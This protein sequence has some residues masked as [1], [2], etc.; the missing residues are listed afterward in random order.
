MVQGLSL[1]GMALFFFASSERLKNQA[2][3][4][5]SRAYEEVGPTLESRGGSLTR[6]KVYLR[7]ARKRL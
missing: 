5:R 4:C 3:L 2:Q 7:I 6:G 1:C